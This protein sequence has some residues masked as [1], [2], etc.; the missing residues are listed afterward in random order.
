M[1]RACRC[2]TA[3]PASRRT[4]ASAY[5]N[6]LSRSG[7]QDGRSGGTGLGLAICKRIV[8]EH[9]GGIAIGDAPGGGAVFHV[10]LPRAPG[11]YNEA[12]AA[13]ALAPR[14]AR[15]GVAAPGGV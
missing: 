5:S 9:G 8:E 6:P 15:G 4:S 2:P 1:V 10:T 3:A 14:I 13:P 11:R 12:V 7:P